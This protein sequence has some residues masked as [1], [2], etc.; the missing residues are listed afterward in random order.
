MGDARGEVS[1]RIPAQA[2]MGGLVVAASVFVCV[3]MTAAANR[4][5]DAVGMEIE[6][7]T[8]SFEVRTNIAAVR[9]H[10]KSDAVIARAQ[11]VS[12]PEG[13]VLE[14]ISASVAAASLK[15]GLSLRDEHMRKYIFTTADG[16]VPD[17]RFSG[18]RT[19]CLKTGS[20][21]RFACTVSGT[22]VIRDTAKPFTIVLT[23]D[24]EDGNL[25]ASGDGI[26]RLSTYGID[27]PSQLGV[28]TTD[29]V[30]LKLE[31]SVRRPAA[32]VAVRAG[33]DR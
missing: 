7:G 27:R 30:K 19:E 31:F 15:T 29:E 18:G 11:L 5:D 17:V 4:T 33:G 1:M 26:V 10:G 8:V 20:G 21:Q 14:Q 22:L 16:Q 6:R 25:R 13:M 28:R 2:L 12:G 24:E 23:I 3:S 32:Q 9:V